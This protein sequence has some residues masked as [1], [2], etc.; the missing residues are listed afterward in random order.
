MGAVCSLRYALEGR[1]LAALELLVQLHDVPP[2]CT[3]E[4][5]HLPPTSTWKQSTAVV[6]ESF[7]QLQFHCLELLLCTAPELLWL[8]L[9]LMC[10]PVLTAGARR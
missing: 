6:C 4:G 3:K 7:A 8:Q 9:V 5:H 2:G 10:E 1:L